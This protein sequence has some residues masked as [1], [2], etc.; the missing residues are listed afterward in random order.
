[1]ADLQLSLLAIRREL[2]NPLIDGLVK[3]EGIDLNITCADP[4]TAFWRE[5]HFQEFDI[6]VTSISTLIAEM[7]KGL[8][9]VGLPVYT[10]RR[11]MHTELH[12]HVDSGIEGPADLDGKRIGIGHYTMTTGSVIR[13]ALQHDFGVPPERMEWRVLPDEGLNTRRPGFAPPK[14]V[15]MTEVAP[16]KGIPGML[17]N[18]EI[19]VCPL[20]FSFFRGANSL[21]EAVRRGGIRERGDWSKVRPLFPD[22]VAESARFFN[23]HGF[24]PATHTYVIRGDVHR[25]HPWVALNLYQAMVEAKRMVD[26]S[27]VDRVPEG[28]LFGREYAAQTRE[29]LRGKDPF[30]YGVEANRKMVETLAGWEVEQGLATE[31]PKVEDLF[32][33]TTLDD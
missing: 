15:S 14:G 29:L 27:M 31:I 20:S 3:P 7:P 9:V 8:D 13:G 19:D 2:I 10:Q 25:K 30:P 24:M 18:H 6:T 12:Y 5:S 11:F 1:M 33:P 17:V 28:L 21:S 16:G 26:D 22:R 23:E 32:A 4:N